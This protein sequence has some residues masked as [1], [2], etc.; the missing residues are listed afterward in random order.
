MK[1]MEMDGPHLR[2][3]AAKRVDDQRTAYLSLTLIARRYSSWA[4]PA[5]AQNMPFR[6]DKQ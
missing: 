1:L 4:L 6:Q 3:E 2:E 5:R